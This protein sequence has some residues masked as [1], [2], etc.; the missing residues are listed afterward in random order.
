MS[1]SYMVKGLK[2]GPYKSNSFRRGTM[3]L[4]NV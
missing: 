3:A 2:T 1:L 4:M